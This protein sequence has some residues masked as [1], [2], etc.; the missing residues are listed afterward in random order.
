MR[1]GVS[2][3]QAAFDRRADALAHIQRGQAGGVA[4]QESVFLP[5]FRQPLAQVIGVRAGLVVMVADQA[6]PVELF[7]Q[8]ILVIFQATAGR[9]KPFGF[10]A[11]ADVHVP[12][13]LRNIPGITGQLVLEKP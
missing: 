6:Q 13:G 12:V 2:G 9:M 11:H 3:H 4:G 7:D 5:D 10:A 8:V 1:D